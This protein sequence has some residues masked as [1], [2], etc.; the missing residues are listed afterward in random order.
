MTAPARWHGEKHCRI[1]FANLEG[2]RERFAGAWKWVNDETLVGTRYTDT[3]DGQ[4]GVCL[5]LAYVDAA[6]VI[7][8]HREH[9][10]YGDWVRLTDMPWPDVH[11][12]PDMQGT[13]P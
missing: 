9:P 7:D 4:P 3:T 1:T 2:R 6:E 8:V 13:Q 5:H 12:T 10:R 11:T